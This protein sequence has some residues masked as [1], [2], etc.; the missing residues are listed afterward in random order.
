MTVLDILIPTFRGSAV[1]LGAYG[2]LGLGAQL[3][4][5]H[6]YLFLSVDRSDVV[7]E[8]VRF[9]LPYARRARVAHYR[10]WLDQVM[11]RAGMRGGWD[12]DHMLAF[13][14]ALFAVCVVGGLALWAVTGLSLVV[15]FMFAI[16]CALL[17]VMRLHSRATVRFIR[18][19]RDLPFS[20][21]FLALAMGAGLDFNQS[22][23]TLATDSVRG[24]LAEEFATVLRNMRIGQGRAEAMHDM[25][26]RLNSPSLRLFVQTITQ[27]LELGSDVVQSLHVMSET[28]QRR[29]F[30]LAEEKAGKISVKMMIPI[31]CFVL[32]S[33]MIVLLAPMLL[34]SQLF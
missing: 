28:F 12:A 29:R 27:S 7:R 32:P 22:L 21:D 26:V 11:G 19:E 23:A 25:A 9:F 20:I 30:Q 18:A 24:P 13:Q 34:S 17:P 6:A 31:M 3:A 33:V 1:A 4:R 16:G 10:R 15:T 2:V 5:N 14:I 8:W